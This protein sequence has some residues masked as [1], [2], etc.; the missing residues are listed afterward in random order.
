MLSGVKPI[1]IKIM[2]KTFLKGQ[3]YKKNEINEYLKHKS[4]QVD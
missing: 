3:L 2:V 4:L 1:K